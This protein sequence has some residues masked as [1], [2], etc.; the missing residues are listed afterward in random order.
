MYS[1]LLLSGLTSTVISTLESRYSFS[2]IAAALIAS[3]FDITVTVVIIFV[4]Y[5]G[6]R[7]HRA[8]WLGI[9]C[10]VQGIGCLVF[11][12]PQFIFFNSVDPATSETR[13]Q[14][15]DS[16]RNATVEC[17]STNSIAYSILILGNI[18]IG[19]GASPLFTVGISYLD[20]L[21]HP[22]Y[23]S[24]HLA[25][26]YLLQVIGP[27]FGFGV[28]GGLLTIYIDPWISTSLRQTS[29]GYLG[30]WWIGFILAGILSFIIAI[31]FFMYPRQLKDAAEVAKAR[32]EEMSKKGQ[33][34]PDPSASMKEVIL[35]LFVQLKRLFTNL[36]FLLVM[37]S[38]TVGAISTT[39]L[40]TFGPKYVESQFSLLASTANLLVGG[41][42]VVAAGK[43]AFCE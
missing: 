42:A 19:L 16:E 40:V 20:E 38:V 37:A 3:T 15:C 21:V 13:F 33:M 18:L 10:V 34:M 32:E 9:G 12:S 30:A 29:T 6:G 5:F 24:L 4:S 11:A 27:A 36:T 23:I 31:P 28:G 35:D 25:V 39:G 41:T 17:E 14:V 7:G 43:L 22:K 8:R 2:S 1:L 26:I